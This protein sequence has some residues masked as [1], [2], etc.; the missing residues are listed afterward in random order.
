MSSER[1]RDPHAIE[2]DSYDRAAIARLRAG[3]AAWRRVD[4]EGARLVP[5]FPALVDDLF[6]ALFKY[7]VLA[8]P[9][10]DAAPGSELARRI[11]TGVIASE[12]YGVLRLHTL[13]DET[14]AGL[15]AVLL[16]EALLR[17]L[18]EDRVLTSG[19][20]LDLWNLEKKHERAEEADDAADVA[21][22]LEDEAR[23]ARRQGRPSRGDS[24]LREAAQ[25]ARLAARG[26]DAERA[27]KQ[28]Q[29][30]AALERVDQKLDR[31]LRK[32]S[33]DA[34]TRVADLPDA[35]ST[36]G[37]GLGAGGSHDPARAIDLG[38]R[39]AD[40][41]KLKRLAAVFGRMRE[42]ALAVRRKVFERADE[43]LHE[44]RPARGLDDL[45]RLVPHE[46]IALSHPLLRRDFQRRLL[47]GGVQSYALR[48]VDQRGRG[49]LVLC[50]DVSS[51]MAGDKEVWAKAVALTFVE[52]ARRRRR[53]CHALAFSSGEGGL[54]RFDLNPRLPYQVSLDTALDLAEH[55]PGGGTD[56]EAPL[57]AATELLASRDMKRGD[58]VM[59]TDGE[60]EVTPEFR[61]EFV[62][63]KRRRNFS[64]YAILVDVR[65]ARE[66][67]I[68]AL[69]D[70]VA[71]VTDLRADAG[72]LFREPAARRRAA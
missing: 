65:G 4:E 27:Q 23:A 72:P 46:L 44:V 43:E 22:E 59:I 57:R 7:V 68:R 32:A 40:N 9:E 37:R 21:R 29:V 8:T 47:D 15:G 36:W 13:L 55:F 66:E 3:S 56:Y 60:C 67:T 33:A 26:A 2:S 24:A 35:L 6:C 12:A 61:E 71:F 5:Y 42:S 10:E 54:R 52:L 28:R 51:S 18:R 39:L 45:A 64:L 31:A 49:P 14:R 48:G 53:R 70:R 1:H 62:R 30:K 20:L 63:A 17:A 25:A 41:K 34:A 16:A 58:L 19:D 38:R 69:A 50:L 11:V